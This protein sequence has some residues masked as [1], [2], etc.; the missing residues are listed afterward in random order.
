[1]TDVCFHLFTIFRLSLLTDQ[2]AAVQEDGSTSSP[3]RPLPQNDIF[4]APVTP[5]N[6]SLEEVKPD[7]KVSVRW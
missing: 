4:I 5:D 2:A 6:N 1:M 7:F 3:A